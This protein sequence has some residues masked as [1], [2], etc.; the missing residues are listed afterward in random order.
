M[1]TIKQD[2]PECLICFEKID[3]KGD[4]LKCS[5]CKSIYHVECF[6]IWDNKTKTKT[7]ICLVCQLANLKIYSTR[8]RAFWCCFPCVCPDESSTI[9]TVDR[10]KRY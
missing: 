4:Y 6:S 3:N 1:D 2:I 7:P 9:S 10:Y 5:T 8:N